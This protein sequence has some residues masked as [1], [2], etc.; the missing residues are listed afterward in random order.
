MSK[1][2]VEIEIPDGWE[3]LDY[4]PPYLG[5]HFL[6]GSTA[7][8]ATVLHSSYMI[9]LKKKKPMPRRT[10]ELISEVKAVAS[11]GDY[12][13]TQI[14]SSAIDLWVVDADSSSYFYIWR[15]IKEDEDDIKRLS[16][17]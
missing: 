7:I 4:R 16:D 2:T 14:T 12:F 6:D 15:E 9:I 8:Q 3:Y 5:D 11:K 13:S 17:R 1:Q 10:F